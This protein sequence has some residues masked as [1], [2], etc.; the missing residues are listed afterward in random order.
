MTY[1]DFAKID[2]SKFSKS[3]NLY[4][5]EKALLLE[6]Q[7]KIDGPDPTSENFI[8]VPKNFGRVVKLHALGPPELLDANFL[9]C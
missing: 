8:M 2:F 5:S 4:F 6:I 9:A 7:Y 1:I 3:G